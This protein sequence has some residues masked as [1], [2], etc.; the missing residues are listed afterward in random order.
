MVRLARKQPMTQLWRPMQRGGEPM[1]KNYPLDR[2]AADVS[3]AE[4]YAG[5]PLFFRRAAR[6]GFRSAQH[7]R[8]GMGAKGAY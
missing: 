4:R 3:W 2:R 5:P 1:A 7:Q 6:P 8:G